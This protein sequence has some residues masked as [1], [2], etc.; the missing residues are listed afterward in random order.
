MA[1]KQLAD[2]DADVTYAL[3]GRD[4]KSGKANPTS[5]EGY[6]IGFRQVPSP[7]SK[8]GFAALHIFQTAKGNVGVWG[9]TNLDNKLGRVT[10]G[11]M[12]R[13]T[14]TGMKETKNNPM[15]TYSV[16]VDEENSIDVGTPPEASSAVDEDQA[17]DRDY[18]ED[19][20]PDSDDGEETPMDEVP[21]ARAAASARPVARQSSPESRA[22]VQALLNKARAGAKSA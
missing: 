16:E 11:L 9:K 10:P 18:S 19:D 4:K 6:Y 20:Y 13:V 15:Y 12:T 7:K 2:L 17:A 3:G 22:K 5:I 8:T 1:F 21:P 14:F